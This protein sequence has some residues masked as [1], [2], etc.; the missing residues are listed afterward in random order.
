MKVR[1][2]GNEGRVE[3]YRG[4]YFVKKRTKV[5]KQKNFKPF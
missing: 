4:K 2:T 3:H 1:I 5:G